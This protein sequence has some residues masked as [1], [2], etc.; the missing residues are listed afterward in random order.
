MAWCT[1]AIFIHLNCLLNHSFS[2]SQFLS[3]FCPSC[4]SRILLGTITPGFFWEQSLGSLLFCFSGVAKF[5]FLDSHR[6]IYIFYF[7][8]IS[9]RFGHEGKINVHTHAQIWN[10]KS[11]NTLTLQHFD[12][13]HS[14][15]LCSGSISEL[16]LEFY[17]HSYLFVC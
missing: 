13:T 8:A 15:N 16:S 5:F 2:G 17:C 1:C 14:R 9:N 3:Y 12:Q 6:I 10:S 11:A 4:P 7:S